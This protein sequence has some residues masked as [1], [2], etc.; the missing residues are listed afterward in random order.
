MDGFLLAKNELIC[1]LI[2]YCYH[3]KFKNIIYII[4]C[5]YSLE[6]L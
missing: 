4:V 3:G 5:V 2:I 6:K 1:V